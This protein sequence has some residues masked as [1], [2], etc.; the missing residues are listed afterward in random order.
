MLVLFL[1]IIGFSICTAQACDEEDDDK[2][3]NTNNTDNTNNTN[4]DEDNGS[5]GDGNSSSPS[6]S[7]NHDYV[8]LGLS[9]KWATCNVGA[10][11]PSA[12]GN[13]YS[14]GE[15]TT[16]SD[17]S[18]SNRSMSDISGNRQYDAARANWGGNWRLPTKAEMEELENQCTWTWTTQGGNNGYR[19]TSKKNGQSIFLPASGYIYGTLLL[20]AGEHGCYWSSTPNGNETNFAY[21]LYFD[22]SGSICV[23]WI[24]R[25]CG[26]SVRPVLE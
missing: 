21:S 6:G 3:E 19:V 14:W 18:S 12:Y 25:S 26:R 17:Y 8:D 7:I 2:I 20:E 11:S 22:S 23:Y 16:K 24:N 5:S 1:L 9:V 10:S 4:K 15:T 13:Y